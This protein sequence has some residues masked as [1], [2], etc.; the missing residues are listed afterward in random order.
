[1]NVILE[2][3]LDHVSAHG[4]YD[5]LRAELVRHGHEITLRSSTYMSED[6][7]RDHDILISNRTVPSHV[8]RLLRCYGG[9]GW[10]R[11]ESLSFLRDQGVETMSW[12]LAADRQEV[13]DLFDQWDVERILLKRSGTLKMMGLVTFA[14]AG[15]DRLEWDPGKDVFCKEVNPDDGDLFKMELFNGQRI[16]SWMARQVPIR[17]IFDGTYMESIPVTKPDRILFDFPPE[18]EATLKDAGRAATREGVGYTSV[19][20]M[21]APDGRLQAI[22]MNVELVATWWTAQF[23]FVKE[24]YA[25]A[26]LD[27]L[28]ARDMANVSSAARLTQG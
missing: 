19:D 12:S 2:N 1:M 21:R 28:A 7:L 9:N 6:A 14:R 23:P 26:L 13:L 24:R 15:V 17:T 3:Y 25:A 22:E 8:R 20:L 11:P 10:T 27:L 16:I 5:H 18:L 4:L